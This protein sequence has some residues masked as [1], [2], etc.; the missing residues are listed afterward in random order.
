MWSF[1]NWKVHGA[2]LQENDPGKMSVW[3]TCQK[4]LGKNWL[5]N[6]EKSV[7]IE[8]FGG[9]LELLESQSDE[10]DS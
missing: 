7:E 3:C 6:G 5:C 9:L 1:E 2:K 4:L 8:N 10:Y